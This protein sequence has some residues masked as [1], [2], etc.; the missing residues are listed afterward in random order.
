MAILNCFYF[1][2]GPFPCVNSSHFQLYPVSRLR[3]A[4]HVLHTAWKKTS[5][6]LPLRKSIKVGKKSYHS[7]LRFLLP[8]PTRVSRAV[9]IRR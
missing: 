3:L 2:A 5:W 7:P 1:L 4:N 8:R 9:T 6:P